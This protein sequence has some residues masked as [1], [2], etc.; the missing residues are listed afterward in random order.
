MSWPRTGR[1]QRLHFAGPDKS[2]ERRTSCASLN[3]PTPTSISHLETT[4]LISSINFGSAGLIAPLMI[5][6]HPYGAAEIN[7]AS[8]R[9]NSSTSYEPKSKVSALVVISVAVI[10]AFTISQG[11]DRARR[12]IPPNLAAMT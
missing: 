2:L 9:G 12:R 1:G 3:S 8:S 4:P 6:H 5:S 7:R 11:S 10:V